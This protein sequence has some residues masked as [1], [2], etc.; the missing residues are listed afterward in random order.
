M[1]FCIAILLALASI[2]GYSQALFENKQTISNQYGMNQGDWVVRHRLAFVGDFN[3]DGKK[4]LIFQGK[5]CSNN[6]YLILG[7]GT[8]TFNNRIV[9][10]N[11]Y[12]MS[13]SEWANDDCGSGPSG[14]ELHIGD[15]NGDG[16]DDVLLQGRYTSNSTYMLYGSASG[17]SNRTNIDWY[18]GMNKTDWAYD[19]NPADSNPSD[20]TG[21]V[22]RIGDFTGDGKDDILLQARYRTNKTYLLK[23]SPG[24]FY[25]RVDI[26]NSSAISQSIWAYFDSHHT[27]VSGRQ[28]HVGD[29]NGDSFADLF[30]QGRYKWNSSYLITGTSSGFNNAWNVNNASGM[31]RGEWVVYDESPGSNSGRYA[32]IGDFNGDG[33]T[34]IVLQGRKTTNNSYL[35]KGNVVGFQARVQISNLYGMTKAEWAHDDRE[36]AVGNF[37]GDNYDD[38]LLRGQSSSH[39]SYI[40]SGNGSGFSNRAQISNL[41][42]MSKSQWA[43]S[44]REAQIG[45]FDGDGKEDIVLQGKDNTNNTL[46]MESKKPTLSFYISGP[47]IINAP[48][49]VTLSAVITQGTAPYS[50]SWKRLDHI[51]TPV[52]S[53]SSYSQFI[54]ATTTFSV[55]VTDANNLSKSSTITVFLNNCGGGFICRVLQD[56]GGRINELTVDQQGSLKKGLELEEGMVKEAGIYSVDGKFLGHLVKDFQE[57][58]SAAQSLAAG[59]Y[60]VRYTID[61]GK[62]LSFNGAFMFMEQP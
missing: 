46:L 25:N 48:T 22:I 40:L 26:S 18:Y 8:N 44:E 42:G 54:G 61:N 43:D 62:G 14:H 39:E 30:V 19:T 36:L 60:M 2:Q 57:I 53:G 20:N 58:N 7:S 16:K 49:T 50:Y 45:D 21:H 13:R 12:G 47:T 32:R 51:W 34:D 28:I 52:G 5:G 23:S 4:D 11:L 17:L 35:I 37:N 59:T 29:F 3:G 1:K 56:A 31:S 24:A 27:E 55:T 6:S 15:F 33:K 38:L 41:Y 9:L 10:N